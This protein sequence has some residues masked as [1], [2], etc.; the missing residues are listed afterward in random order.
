VTIHYA[1][2]ESRPNTIGIVVSYPSKLIGPRAVAV[3]TQ[4][5][6]RRLM[7]AAERRGWASWLE[8]DVHV[9]EE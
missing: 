7:E 8:M 6:K 1:W 9:V 4:Q 2:D 5:A 3:R